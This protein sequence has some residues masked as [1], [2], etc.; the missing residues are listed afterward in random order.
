MSRIMKFYCDRCKK[1][2]DPSDVRCK[3][4]TYI[5]RYKV[6]VEYDDFEDKCDL[7]VDC[8]EKLN[9]FMN[10]GGDKNEECS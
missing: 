7:C 9:K 1:E 3:C 2:F 6:M 10:L 5:Y 8:F 4:D